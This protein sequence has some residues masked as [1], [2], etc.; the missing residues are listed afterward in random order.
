ML[1]PWPGVPMSAESAILAKPNRPP[2][3]QL[4]QTMAKQPAEEKCLTVIGVDPG[5]TTGIAV[6]RIPLDTMYGDAKGRIVTHW[7]TEL[8]GPETAQ[9]QTFCRIAKRYIWPAVALEDFSLRTKV[10]SREV[11]ASPRVASK[12]HFCIETGMAGEVTGLEWQMPAM[13]FETMPD[14]RL[15]KAGLWTTGSDH[16]RDASRHAMTLIRRAKADE[17]LRRRI[18]HYPGHHDADAA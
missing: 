11:L 7:T 12:I 1:I 9:A 14:D 16:I 4:G 2:N 17:K 18:F 5:E 8:S 13:A 6:I 15:R 3:D 10:T